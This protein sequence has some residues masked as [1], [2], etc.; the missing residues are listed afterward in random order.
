MPEI[1]GPSIVGVDGVRTALFEFFS[2][3]T[4]WSVKDLR[5]ASVGRLPERE[6]RGGVARH[7]RLSSNGRAQEYVGAEIGV[8][9]CRF[10]IGRG[11]KFQWRGLTGG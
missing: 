11:F 4:M 2:K 3:R 6:T 10:V 7:R 8:Q 5:Y 1:T 9:E